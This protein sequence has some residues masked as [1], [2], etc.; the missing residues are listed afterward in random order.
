MLKIVGTDKDK[1]VDEK[2][3]I[4]DEGKITKFGAALVALDILE[5]IGIVYLISKIVKAAK[6]G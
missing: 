2:V 4:T 6:K 3:I 5:D 1:V